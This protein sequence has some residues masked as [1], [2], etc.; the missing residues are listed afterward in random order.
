MASIARNKF[1]LEERKT[2]KIN[3]NRK[4]MEYLRNV[5]FLHSSY[6]PL[7]ERTPSFYFETIDRVSHV[8]QYSLLFSC[9]KH[10]RPN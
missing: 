3:V 5:T 7:A 10:R 2:S 6:N 8:R 1:V 4:V 9:I